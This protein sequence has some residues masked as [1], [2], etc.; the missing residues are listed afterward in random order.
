VR[1][2]AQALLPV[3]G[4]LL[5]GFRPEEAGA[6]NLK[7][8]VD[9]APVAERAVSGY[10]ELPIPVSKAAEEKFELRFESDSKPGWGA[11]SGDDR[12]LAFIL[13]ELRAQ[14]PKGAQFPA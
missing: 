12:D 4:V 14:H 3:T 6:T 8:L 13:M 10:F 1:I 2:R 7:V 11:A 5:R 9:G